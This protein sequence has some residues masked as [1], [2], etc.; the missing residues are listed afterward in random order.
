MNPDVQGVRLSALKKRTIIGSAA[1]VFIVGLSGP[2]VSQNA[3]GQSDSYLLT[4]SGW[5]SLA[6]GRFEAALDTFEAALE[7]DPR[8]LDAVA[9]KARALA[10]TGET[11]SGTR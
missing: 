6:S 2:G 7:A 9:G 4:Q 5:A 8:D 1:F 10:S 3:S 11:R